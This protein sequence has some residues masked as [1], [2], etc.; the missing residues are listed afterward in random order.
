MKILTA[1]LALCATL[2]L[3][4]CS[5]KKPDVTVGMTYDEVEKLLG[6]PGQITRG[7]SQLST[8][9]WSDTI[10]AITNRIRFGEY[11]QGDLDRAEALVDITADSAARAS[12]DSLIWLVPMNVETTGQLIY[13]TWMYPE[14]KVDTFHIFQK[15]FVTETDT[16]R[17]EF[18]V[19]NGKYMSGV[20]TTYF[21]NNYSIDRELYTHAEVGGY[22]G[23]AFNLPM[24]KEV[25][26][27]HYYKAGLGAV[28]VGV[29]GDEQS[30]K[31]MQ[32]A[33]Y[34]LISNK[35]IE[36]KEI[37]RTNY[38]SKISQT[39]R[40]KRVQQPSAKKYYAVYETRC[41]TF[42]AS[43]GRVVTAGYQPIFV[44]ECK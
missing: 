20:D 10:Q 23:P 32:G 14:T 37:Y 18:S 31:L 43:S 11:S 15:V 13:I 26:Y 35:H 5:G 33:G 29:K 30:R 40:P 24:L 42:D 34:S 6:K 41:V 3:V 19:A 36:T 21:L 22:W 4:S 25:S 38:A 44:T 27:A 12:G 16:V 2:S 8:D 7:V 9:Q 39:Y 1:L 28:V 17:K